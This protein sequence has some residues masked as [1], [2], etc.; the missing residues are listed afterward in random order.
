MAGIR[1]ETMTYAYVRKTYG[2]PRATIV[3][4]LNGRLERRAAHVS[5]RLLTK[6]QEEELAE[7]IMDLD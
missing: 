6:E 1:D 3:G 2:I 7:W 5:Q 4:R